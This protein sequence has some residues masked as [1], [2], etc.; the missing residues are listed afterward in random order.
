MATVATKRRAK[1]CKELEA[2]KGEIIYRYCHEDWSMEKVRDEFNRQYNLNATK[3]QYIGLLSRANVRKRL[4]GA[5]WR[6]V[7]RQLQSRTASGKSRSEIKLSRSSGA[8]ISQKQIKRARRR[9]VSSTEEIFLKH[10]G[11][12][13]LSDEM[14]VNYP[15]DVMTPDKEESLILFI[16]PKISLRIRDRLLIFQVDNLLAQAFRQLVTLHDTPFQLSSARSH[17]LLVQLR[18]LIYRLSNNLVEFGEVWDILDASDRLGYR[19]I[20][21]EILTLQTAS[22]QTY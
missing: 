19:Q 15:V 5:E 20:M 22:I 21:K 16:K 17:P 4:T 9:H 6:E 1:P 10:E 18:V 8:L 12:S 2:I 13:L 11:C 14:D 7:N 3:S